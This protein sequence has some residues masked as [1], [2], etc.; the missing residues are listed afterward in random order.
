MPGMSL[1]M[2]SDEH[3]IRTRA[4]H[5]IDLAQTKIFWTPLNFRF[6]LSRKIWA[7]LV[8]CEYFFFKHEPA[9]RRAFRTVVRGLCTIKHIVWLV[10]LRVWS[11]RALP[12]T[13]FS[14]AISWS[15]DVFCR[16]LGALKADFRV[17][18]RKLS[19]CGHKSFPEFPESLFIDKMVGNR[20]R[21][22]NAVISVQKG[23]FQ[24]ISP[25][26]RSWF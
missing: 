6:W 10:Y 4:G 7:R 22:E 25:Q 13:S 8:F 24:S 15:D 21:H 11:A 2:W 14:T 17:F 20:Y 18:K 5:S 9:L 12:A 16:F 26:I 1:E 3:Q 23:D 19:L